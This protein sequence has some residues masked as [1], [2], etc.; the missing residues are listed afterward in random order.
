MQR[1][2]L[3]TQCSD[4]LS[5]SS[6]GLSRS[7][8]VEIALHILAPRQTFCIS[9]LVLRLGFVVSFVFRAYMK[10]FINIGIRRRPQASISKFCREKNVL[11]SIYAHN[12]C[13]ESRL[14]DALALFALIDLHSFLAFNGITFIIL[15]TRITCIPCIT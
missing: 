6:F 10:I 2:R 9:C 15:I 13:F 7:P 1:C 11:L 4:T 14:K 8:F 12:F 3:A 5:D